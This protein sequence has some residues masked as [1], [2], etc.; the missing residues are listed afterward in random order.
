[1]EE[2]VEQY[3]TQEESTYFRERV[4]ARTQPTL[5]RALVV[6]VCKGALLTE[7]KVLCMLS[8]IRG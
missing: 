4:I 7:F 6:L 3:L 8:A 2:K 1:M 5:T